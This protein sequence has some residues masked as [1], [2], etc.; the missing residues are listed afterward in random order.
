[1]ITRAFQIIITNKIKKF[2]QF[3]RNNLNPPVSMI[4]RVE[5]DLNENYMISTR[6]FL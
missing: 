5:V 4:S 2:Q 6:N 1:M 3:H